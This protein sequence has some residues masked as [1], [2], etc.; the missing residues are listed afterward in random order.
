MR[1]GVIN[2]KP[3]RNL[4]VYSQSGYNYKE[5]PTILL[6]GDWL[7]ECGF[8]KGDYIK[9]KCSDKKLVIELDLD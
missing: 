6:K 2:I 9:V 8:D 5:V 1:K 3:E 4:K 7:R